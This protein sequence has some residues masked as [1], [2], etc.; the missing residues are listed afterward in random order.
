MTDGPTLTIQDPLN[1][2]GDFTLDAPTAVAD[3]YTCTGATTTCASVTV[4]LL[5]Q[6]GAAVRGHLSVASLGGNYGGT[7]Y[8]SGV[9]HGVTVGCGETHAWYISFQS[10]FKTGG[11]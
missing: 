4:H 11:P 8:I 1:S 3:G 5:P 10:T 2:W 7:G 9:A 6:A